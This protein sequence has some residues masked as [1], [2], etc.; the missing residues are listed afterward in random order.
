MESLTENG[1]TPLML[2]ALMGHV[3]IVAILRQHEASLSTTNEFGR[4]ALYYTIDDVSNDLRRDS[5]SEHFTEKDP[6][7]AKLRRQLIAAALQS[8]SKPSPSV[9][10]ETIQTS[11]PLIFIRHER[12]IEMF[13]RIA[14]VTIP[15]ARAVTK[16]NQSAGTQKARLPKHSPRS[17]P[18]A[19]FIQ[20]PVLSPILRNRHMARFHLLLNCF[21]TYGYSVTWRITSCPGQVQPKITGPSKFH[22]SVN[23]LLCA[24]PANATFNDPPTALEWKW[25]T[26]THNVYECGFHGQLQPYWQAP[27]LATLLTTT[28]SWTTGLGCGY[29]AVPT[30]TNCTRTTCNPPE[31]TE[32]KHG[33]IS[34]SDDL[35]DGR[36]LLHIIDSWTDWQ[37]ISSVAG[38]AP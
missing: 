27:L 10:P 26:A 38:K 25:H 29:T 4:N 17:R 14:D 21:T 12:R 20:E 13:Q 18:P 19:S 9:H 31:P 2:A 1:E 36:L 37:C 15:R 6:E 28:A 24:I 7:G 11:E 33:Y 22:P 35:Q 32:T 30:G 16:D 34:R 8:S 3:E 5:Y 23:Q